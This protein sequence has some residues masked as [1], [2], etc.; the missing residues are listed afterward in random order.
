MGIK[1]APKPAESEGTLGQTN[2]MGL[3]MPKKICTN[4]R[5]IVVALIRQWAR[6][7]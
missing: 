7:L 6:T 4:L 2:G 1:D 5:F 3:I